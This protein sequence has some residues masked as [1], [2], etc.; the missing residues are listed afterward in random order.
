M[1][2]FACARPVLFVNDDPDF[3][4]SVTGTAFVLLF[5]GTLL[6]R[7]REARYEG[8]QA[9]ASPDP[10][11]TRFR[12]VH[13]V[14]KTGINSPATIPPTTTNSMWWCGMSIGV[15]PSYSVLIGPICWVRTTSGHGRMPREDGRIT[16][17]VDTQGCSRR[18]NCSTSTREG[19]RA[20]FGY[21]AR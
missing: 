15:G 11:P 10:I 8:I 6:R 14:K 18:I 7:Q 19:V 20:G 5:R 12:A 3:P 4:I 9:G 16:Y 21:R 2:I 1:T 13:S 17:I